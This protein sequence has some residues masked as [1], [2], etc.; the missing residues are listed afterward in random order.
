LA[1]TDSLRYSLHYHQ[2]CKNQE[3][4]PKTITAQTKQ[5]AFISYYQEKEKK[6]LR[7]KS[8]TQFITISSVMLPPK[9]LPLGKKTSYRQW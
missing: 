8:V 2:H 1:V 3:N 6:M 9:A 7:F 4:A 5:I